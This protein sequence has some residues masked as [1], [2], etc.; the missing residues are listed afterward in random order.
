METPSGNIVLN[1]ENFTL[2]FNLTAITVL[3]LSYHPPEGI[4]LPLNA[5]KYQIILRHGIDPKRKYIVINVKAIIKNED[6]SVVLGAIEVAHIFI[7]ENFEDVVKITDESIVVDE[8]AL[9]IL[10]P[11]SISTTRGV[12][13]E[14]FQNTAISNAVMPVYDLTQLTPM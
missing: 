5:Y 6:E 9:S 8:K 1:Q 11:I 14:K 7:V 12:A 3:E 13:F 10:H 2:T 4:Q